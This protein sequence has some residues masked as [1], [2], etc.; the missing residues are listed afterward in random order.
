M[1][2]LVV[3]AYISLKRQKEIKDAKFCLWRGSVDFSKDH[4]SFFVVLNDK[5]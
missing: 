3:D 5:L 1:R 4:K 2:Y